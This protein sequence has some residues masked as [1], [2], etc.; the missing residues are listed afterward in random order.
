MSIQRS[1][2]SGYAG[3]GYREGRE[4]EDYTQDEK[5][6]RN[7]SPEEREKYEDRMLLSR[8][9]RSIGTAEE[10]AQYNRFKST[11]ESDKE[12]L[13]F[14]A[15]DNYSAKERYLT[16]KGYTSTPN[17]YPRDVASLIEQNDIAVGMG[18]QAV[19]ESWGD[20]AAIEVAGRPENGNERW[21]YKEYISTPEGF[22]EENR[23]LYFENGRVVGWEKY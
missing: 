6:V 8:L 4:E 1:N 23:V 19:L 3:T 22:Q 21:T 16:S 20:P 10:R 11:L 2:E 18:R 17:R 14:L 12:R 13:E 9:E 5:E 15:L 7:L